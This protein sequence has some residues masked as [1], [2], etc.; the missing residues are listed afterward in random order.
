LFEHGPKVSNEKNPP[1]KKWWGIRE[2]F[3]PLAIFIFI[4]CNLSKF[5]PEKHL[6]LNFPAFKI[7]IDQVAKNFQKEKHW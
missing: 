5:T 3:F 7:I 2:D 1:F 4:F 6:S